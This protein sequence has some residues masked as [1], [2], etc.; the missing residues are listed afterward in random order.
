MKNPKVMVQVGNKGDIG[1]VEITDVLFSA[2]GA[3]AGAI[4]TEW[5]VAAVSQ[6]AAAMWASHFRV[7][8]ALGTDLDLSKCLKF[9]NNAE[10]VAA[11]LL[12]RV[13]AQTNGHF[14]NVWAWVSDHD[15]DQS[16]YT[17][18]DSSST[19][20]SIFAARGMLIE[21]EGPS[22]FYGGGSEH[23]V[24]YNHLI[25]GAKSVFMGHIQTESPY[26]QPVPGPP[27][28]F[29]AAASFPNDLDFSGCEVATEVW[30]DRC[31]YA[32]GLQIIDSEDVTIHSAGLYSF[33]NEYY[34][35]CVPTHNCQDR[36]LVVKGSTGVVIYNLFTVG[37]VNMASD[38]DDT[39]V[40]QDGNQRGFTTEISV[41][42]RLPGSDNVDICGLVPTCGKRP[43]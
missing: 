1:T 5:N 26:Y 30:D 29:R 36:I 15:N 2:R 35:D 9:S 16:I 20:I 28:P 4:L 31:N 14:E 42:V 8:G 23:S 27:G 21:S 7:G 18:P 33:F 17:Q 25:S 11:S 34:Q 37:T 39:N 24:L 22:W 40:P 43:R 41:W 10:C 6:G 13:T 32:W 3:T 38:M 12:F 19:Q